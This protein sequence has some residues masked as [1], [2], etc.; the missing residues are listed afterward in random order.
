MT[1]TIRGVC[2]RNR[3]FLAGVCSAVLMWAGMPAAQ[4]DDV[5]LVTDKGFVSL[6]TF[7]NNSDFKISVD[8]QTTTGDK[9]DLNR[10]F[11]DQDV[12]RFRLDGL[13]RF[14]ERHHLRVM[15]TDYSRK[16]TATVERQVTWNDDVFDIGVEATAKQ[17]FTILEA[18]Y[19][20]AFMHSD[21]YELAGT[22]GLH[23]T[24]V[25]LS[26]KADVTLPGGGGTATIGGPASVDMPLPVIGARG[27][28][29]FGQNFYFD[30]QVQYFA[31]SIDNVD[32]SILNYRG[33][34]MW[35]PKKWIGLGLGYDSFNIDVD[36]NKPKFK[37]TMD[38]TYQGPQL[39]YNVSF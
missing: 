4:A 35:Q 13:W 16:K 15:Y 37:G 5:N 26:L 3:V 20:Y 8:G 30:A 7:L 31:L 17:S 18:A 14:N 25:D 36:L 27:L 22:F 33:A 38:W 2:H 19:E 1:D 21:K 39:F 28:W 24:T 23:Y 11:G 6:G 34:L 10:T 9:I 29:R 32:G 12:T